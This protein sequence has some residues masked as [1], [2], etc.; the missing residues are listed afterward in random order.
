MGASPGKGKP[1]KGKKVRVAFRQNRSKPPRQNDWTRRAREADANEIDAHASENLTA[2]GDLT[3]QRT[4]MLHGDD[5]FP[6]EL[7]AG[8]VV[9]MR[10][11][12]ADVD[13]ATGVIPC[14]VSR[15]LRTRL[16]QERHPVAVGDHVGFRLES[17]GDDRTEEG[18]IEY[19]APRHGELRRL[20]GRRVHTIVANVDQAIIV[21]SAAKPYPKPHLIDRYIV[22]SLAGGITPI[23]CMNKVDLDESGES[24]MVLERYANLDTTV[25][26]TSAETGFGIDALRRAL[27]DK[28][29][30][31]VG[32]SGVGKSSLLNAVQPGLRL[33][34]GDINEQLEKG[35]HTTTTASLIRLD[36]GGYVV[37]TPGIRSFDLTT[38]PRHEYEAYFLEF[39]DHIAHCKFADCTHIHEAECAVIQAV[40]DG[41]VHPD[42]Y[43]SYVRIFEEPSAMS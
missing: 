42:R 6:P 38:V 8:V 28:S 12:Y 3:R 27:A 13:A 26:E 33:R 39:A 19:V 18:M 36:L 31:I 25:L 4:I 37:D 9:T 20:S 5:G 30:V 7:T 15:V 10:G 40:E 32:Q 16:I 35:R 1:K 17:S 41:K 14:T 24:R 29:T 22:A 11:L 34:I 43:E 21:T 2:K 23:I